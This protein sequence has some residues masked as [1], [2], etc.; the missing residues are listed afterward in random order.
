VRNRRNRRSTD[1]FWGI[2]VFGVHDLERS[3]GAG[4]A[5]HGLVL[6]ITVFGV[7]DLERSAGA[8][9]AE[10]GL[11]RW[12]TVFAFDLGV[13]LRRVGFSHE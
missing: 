2:T 10:H 6:G 12:I 11:V 3:A 4:E 9:E 13:G 7:H 8:D 5:E 1:S